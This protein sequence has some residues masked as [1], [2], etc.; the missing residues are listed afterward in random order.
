MTCKILLLYMKQCCDK[1]SFSLPKKNQIFDKPLTVL[2][3]MFP[4]SGSSRS[5]MFCKTG[6]YKIHRKTPVSKYFFNKVAGLQHATF[7]KRGS[8]WGFSNEI[9]KIFKT[10]YFIEL[11]QATASAFWKSNLRLCK[12]TLRKKMPF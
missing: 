3:L 4:F 12:K 1:T 10:T 5:Q 2:L 6:S 7:W 8:H 11:F 9:F